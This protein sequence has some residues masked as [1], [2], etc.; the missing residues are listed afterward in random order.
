M[1][2]SETVDKTITY[3]NQEI[4]ILRNGFFIRRMS[5]SPN[6]DSGNAPKEGL[7]FF[8]FVFVSN[9]EVLIETAEN[10]Y[11]CMPGHAVIIPSQT[12]FIVRYYQTAS[13]YI[14]G[15]DMSA[16]PDSKPIRFLTEPLHKAFWFDEGVFMCELFNMIQVSFE[17]GD[18]TFVQKGF[19]L[20]ISRIRQDHNTAVISNTV[21]NFLELIFSRDHIPGNLNLYATSAGISVNYLSRQ[22]KQATG[23]SAGTW[24]DIARVVK[25][26]RL[27]SST[28]MAIIDISAAVGLDDQ[29]YFA[30][31]FKREVGLTPTDYRKSMHG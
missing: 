13:G 7:P 21:S 12:S 3:G 26:K 6:C 25:A 31:F 14:G 29:S 10:T 16:I 15:F 2:E 19:D 8:G 4:D 20:F 27:L 28:S 30:R 17:K 5:S 18:D 11:I 23:R 1:G 22:I 24:I 9:G